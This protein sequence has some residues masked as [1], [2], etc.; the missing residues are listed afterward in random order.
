[1]VG[2]LRRQAITAALTANAL[3]PSKT[4][5][6]GVL[7][8][9]LGWTTVELAPHLLALTAADTGVQLTRRRKS[10]LGLGLAAFSAAGLSREILL[11]RGSGSHLRDALGKLGELEGLAPVELR[12]PAGEWRR[13]LN[14]LPRADRRVTV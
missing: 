8:F 4:F 12:A 10:A 13:Q 6:G 2:Y 14:P 1:G 5:R 11:S 3:R 9:L 7:S